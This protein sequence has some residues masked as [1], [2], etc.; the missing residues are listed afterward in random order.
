MTVLFAFLHHLFAFTLVA[1]LVAELVL[2]REE[3]TA[4]RAKRLAV[5]DAVYGG[6]AGVLLIVGLV[7]VGYLEK[8]AGYYFHSIP[9]LVK[10]GT[11]IV[12]AL[13]S[14]YPTVKFIQWRRAYKSGAVPVTDAAAKRPIQMVIH[15]EA[16]G[17]VVILLC[18]A[19]MARGIG[20][21]G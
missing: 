13:I 9:F 4:Q 7:R 18:A 19:L 15:L 17:V 14:I 21:F 3:I 2:L 12:L 20:F 10:F 6:S 16:L 1:A 11:F 5:F 8:G